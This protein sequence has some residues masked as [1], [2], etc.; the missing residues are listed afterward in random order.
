MRSKAGRGTTGSVLTALE[1]VLGVEA[2]KG[3]VAIEACREAW[4]LHDELVRRDHEVKLVD[5]TRVKKLGIGQHGRKTARIDAEVL[6]ALLREK[7]ASDPPCS[8]A[9]SGP[10]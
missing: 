3:T 7:L 6:A 2:P 1:D 4:H 8:H 5:T 9:T 10:A